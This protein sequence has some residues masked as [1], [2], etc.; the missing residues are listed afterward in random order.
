[1]VNMLSRFA[2]LTKN[3]SVA[4]H[5]ILVDIYIDTR[6][7]WFRITGSTCFSNISI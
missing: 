1:M 5:K 6:I 4:V 7:S 2:M 3:D